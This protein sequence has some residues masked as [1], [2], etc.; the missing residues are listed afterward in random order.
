MQKISIKMIYTGENIHGQG[1]GS[2]TM[3]QIN[4]LRTTCQDYLDIKLKKGKSDITHIH[5]IHLGAFFNAKFSKNP[6]VVHVHFIPETMEG[7]IKMPKVFM[8]LF[9]KYFLSIYKK[10]NQ[11]VVVNPSFIEPLLKYG[12]KR[13]Q[14]TYIPNYVCEQ[15]FYKIDDTTKLDALREKHAIS[16]DDFIVMGVGQVQTRKGVLDFL[17]VAKKM[18]HIKFVWVGGFTFGRITDGYKELSYA[19]K[20]KPDNMILTGIVNRNL[21][22]DYYN[23][24]NLLFMPSYHEL[25]PMAILE[26]ASCEKP[27]LLRNLSL[28]EPILNHSHLQASDVN[29]FIDVIDKLK[30]DKDFYKDA[31]L[32]SLEIKNR[33]SKAHIREEWI[34]FYQSFYDKYAHK[35]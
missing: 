22:N 33:Y 34:R 23:M 29:E 25:F 8:K 26:A 19:L 3:E 11:V 14:I 10:A 13:E 20:H 12:F 24:A 17:E 9:F 21:M 16:K 32:K 4:L 27:I 35:K 7:S 31:V 5:T 2:A 1:V 15:D 18:P 28:Y 6:K 30:S